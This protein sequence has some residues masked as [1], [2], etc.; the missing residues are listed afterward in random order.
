MCLVSWGH[1]YS[2]TLYT[3]AWD[4]IPGKRPRGPKSRVMFKHLWTLTWDTM[5][6]A[7]KIIL[8]G[9][10]QIVVAVLPFAAVLVDFD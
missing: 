8:C 6:R 7:N 9:S 2:S 4:L 5:V 1:C 10:L 3:N